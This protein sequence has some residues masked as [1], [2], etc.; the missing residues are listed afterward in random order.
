MK[1]DKVSKL[2]NVQFSGLWNIRFL[3]KIFLFFKKKY[4]CIFGN[5][6]IKERRIKV[7]FINLIS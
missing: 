3:L 2:S 1:K 4:L 5:L 6:V 7:F